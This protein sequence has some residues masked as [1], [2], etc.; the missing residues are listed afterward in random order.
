MY[1]KR[2]KRGLGDRTAGEIA[3]GLGNRHLMGVESVKGNTKKQVYLYARYSLENVYYLILK[4][5][6]T[7]IFQMLPNQTSPNLDLDF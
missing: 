7:L 2:P 5:P 1:F 3:Q 6:Q 4:S